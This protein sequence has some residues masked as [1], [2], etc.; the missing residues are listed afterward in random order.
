[1]QLDRDQL[2]MFHRTLA[3]ILSL[4]TDPTAKILIQL[5][6]ALIDE[7]ERQTNVSP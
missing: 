5:L 7:Y 4:N 3:I 2:E 6:A 1:M